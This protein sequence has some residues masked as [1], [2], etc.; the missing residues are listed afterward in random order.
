M[1]SALVLLYYNPARYIHTAYSEYTDSASSEPDYVDPETLPT[2]PKN[3][4][5][6]DYPHGKVASNP[7]SWLLHWYICLQ[8]SSFRLYSTLSILR[9][10]RLAL[11]GER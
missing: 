6:D 10:L 7:L 9:H 1:Y 5:E 8:L 4:E 3:E 2:P 11:P